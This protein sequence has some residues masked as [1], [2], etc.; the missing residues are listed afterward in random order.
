MIITKEGHFCYN[1]RIEEGFLVIGNTIGWHG[2]K[3][4][5][6]LFQYNLGHLYNTIILEIDV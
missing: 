3:Y 4:F 5:I 2:T 1:A 6:K